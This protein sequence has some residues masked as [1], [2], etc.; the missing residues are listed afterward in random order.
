MNN[1]ILI[2][3]IVAMLTLIT[4]CDRNK[5]I[6]FTKNTSNNELSK[7]NISFAPITQK[8]IDHIAKTLVVNYRLITNIPTDKCDSKVADGACFEVELSL[9]ANEAILA[10]G[11]AIYFSHI[12]P[13]QSSESEIFNVKHLNGDLHKISLLDKY[14]GIKAG[15]TKKIIFRANF[16]MLSETDALPNYIVTASGSQGK[17]QAKVIE[18]TKAVI[19]KETGLEILPFVQRFTDETTQ[20]KRTSNDKTVWLTSQDLYQRNAQN[21][22]SSLEHLLA[23]ERAI[24]PTPKLI[25]F[26]EN[27]ATIDVSSGLTVDFSNVAINE[28]NAALEHLSSLGLKQTLDG[29]PV[30][31]QI[32]ADKT[33]VIGSY[34]LNVSNKS[35]HIIGVDSNGVF[36]GLQSLASLY[37][38]GRQILPVVNIEDEPH[39]SFRGMLVDVARNFHSK[40]FILSLLE[41]MAAYKLNK[42][43]LHLGD[44]EG[45]RLEIPSLPELTEVASKRCFPIY[46]DKQ[47]QTCLIPQLGAGIDSHSSVNGY[48]SVSD[49][50]E[51]LQAATARHIQVIPSLDMPGHSRAA[52]KAM[53][54]RYKKYQALE[55][56]H[57]ATQFLL[58]DFDDKTQYS[59]VQFYNDNT[60]NV[61]LE[62]SYAFV[63]EVMTQV[64][65]IHA[66]AGQ[67]LTRYHIGADETAGAWVN[68]P[69]CKAFVA[70]NEHGITKMSELGAYF[71]ERVAGI[72]SNLGIE[73]AG[74]SDGMEHTRKENMP[75]I[76]Q[77]NA[78]DV[79]FWGG[80][81]KVHTL[82]N[83]NWQVVI[84]SPDVLYFDFPYEADPKEH[85]YYWASR[86]TNTEKVF[87]FMPDNLPAHAEIWL[88]REDNPYT[89]DDTKSPLEKGQ[90]FL[91]V[92]GQLWS[93][94]TRSDEIAEHKIYPRLLALAERA[95]HLPNWAVPYNYK[96]AVYS[97]KTQAFTADMQKSR[98]NNWHL[99]TNVLGKKEFAKLELAGINYRL[100]TVG[101]VIEQG[102]LKA[103]IAFP[104]L[105]I[106]Y[107]LQGDNVDDKPW[108]TY[109]K[110]VV[111]DTAVFIRS[112]SINGLRTGRITKVPVH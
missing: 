12:S 38:V 102:I 24:I 63:L 83:R 95:W 104:G 31:L 92:Q 44:D 34:Q 85:G 21:E 16:W 82:A 45:W 13:I 103:N 46:N 2:I 87:Q 80:H 84:S 74:W 78:W 23:V 50:Q 69:A 110:P 26:D 10:K 19:E 14:S 30:T 98:D 37:T 8:A 36:N 109:T 91:G 6:E 47:E 90:K 108:L 1:K 71:I 35:I 70:N 96:G 76:V 88:D 61:C 64:K 66:D 73:T 32:K 81:N 97:N 52:M 48:Y 53:T 11:W 29:F 99:F 3:V 22:D 33:K 107:Q 105:T 68:S 5:E 65:K 106:E 39:Y 94:N 112:R 15:E 57:K 9:T 41:Q 86:H 111:V 18:S 4:S 93:E 20:F 54:A 51:I 79:L 58:D 27:K 28:V 75:A 101:A 40:E 25:Q 72:L 60:I 100:P 67:P 59:S 17:L 42:L 49:Y 55:D 56:E 77:A 62:S 43:H 89:A 7:T